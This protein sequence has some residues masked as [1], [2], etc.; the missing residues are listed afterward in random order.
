MQ[1]KGIVFLPA[2]NNFNERNERDL[3]LKLIQQ[4]PESFI[5]VIP[6]GHVFIDAV[7][8][9]Y[10]TSIEIN[11]TQYRFDLGFLDDL[12]KVLIRDKI[13][14]IFINPEK[15]KEY[16]LN[17]FC[18]DYLQKFIE[19]LNKV[20]KDFRIAIVTPGNISKGEL[21]ETGH[22]IR[23]SLE[24]SESSSF[25]I[26]FS[27]LLD[28]PVYMDLF[29]KSVQDDNFFDFIMKNPELSEL[30]QY[31]S[32][33]IGIG[34]TDKLKTL[35]RTF[36][37]DNS[38]AYLLE[39]LV[40]SIDLKDK[41][42]PDFINSSI[43]SKWKE[44]YKRQQEVLRDNESIL[45]KMV[46]ETIKLWL[47]KGIR[48]NFS[49]YSKEEINDESI[50]ERLFRQRTGVFISILKNNTVR[51]SMGTV[52]PVCQNIG[53]EIINNALEAAFFDPDYI[54]LS[55]DELNDCTFMVD[56][57]NPMEQI[58][59]ISELNPKEYGIVLEKGFKR[60]VVLPNTFGINTVEEQ[61]TLAKERAG[62][63]DLID[64]ETPVIINKFTTE[65]F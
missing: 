21:L 59:D 26:V 25:M 35:S 61:I 65:T 7:S 47:D 36:K 29:N 52:T 40:E 4:K 10:L 63:D 34:A 60:G 13:P 62:I 2:N 42:H 8:I 24:R 38:I 64:I 6:E 30:S 55:Q 16:N 1:L 44:D 46:R 22:C 53:E 32:L 31:D 57:L 17:S 48:L 14:S 9:D 20:Y 27:S 11:N 50:R 18:P 58:E 19:L 41:D 33:L 37:K 23:E 12:N 3:I 45:Q 39:F 43:I 5:F 28:N 15:Q 56:V 49:T 51:G 54:P